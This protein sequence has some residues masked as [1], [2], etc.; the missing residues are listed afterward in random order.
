M[1]KCPFNKEECSN[2]CALF[3]SPENL[4]ELVRNR[5]NSIGVF[6]RENGMCALKNIALS[7]SR[8]MF[9]RT[10]TNR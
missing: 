6:D 3:I 4:N 8:Y 1:K 9:E 5:L 10:S 7:S 2:E